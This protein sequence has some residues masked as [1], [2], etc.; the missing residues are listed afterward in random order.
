MHTAASTARLSFFVLS[1]QARS[2]S[3]GWDA[4]V[5]RCVI[6]PPHKEPCLLV[7]AGQLVETSVPPAAWFEGQR[8]VCQSPW[9]PRPRLSAPSWSTAVCAAGKLSWQPEQLAGDAPTNADSPFFKPQSGKG[10]SVQSIK[11]MLS[12]SREAAKLFSDKQTAA[13]EDAPQ[14]SR[15]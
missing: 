13:E 5:R 4:R 14:R 7:A 6:L 15:V 2:G 1:A 12:K 8:P 11:G 10:P 3:C 9:R